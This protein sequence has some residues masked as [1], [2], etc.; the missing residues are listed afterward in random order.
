DGHR[1][2]ARPVLQ[3]DGEDEVRA[4]GVALVLRDVVDRDLALWLRRT[5][6]LRDVLRNR[7][8]IGGPSDLLRR[9]DGDALDDADGARRAVLRE[10]HAAR[11]GDGRQ[12]EDAQAECDG[13]AE[14]RPEPC[15]VTA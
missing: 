14:S 12:R 3:R 9:R 2:V 4:A 6:A 15:R 7:R 10:A 11:G 1:L 13:D 5:A 8:A